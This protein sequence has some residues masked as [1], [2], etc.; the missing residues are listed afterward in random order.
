MAI[1]LGKNP[2]G[3]SS[4]GVYKNALIVEARCVKERLKQLQPKEKTLVNINDHTELTQVQ[5]RVIFLS[6]S[7]SEEI[8]KLKTEKKLLA[9]KIG[10][11][12]RKTSNKKKPVTYQQVEP[13]SERK[14]RIF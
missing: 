13:H 7:T 8:A 2:N 14:L 6:D 11:E 9:K 10:G 12:I 1:E 5:S 4:N 3:I